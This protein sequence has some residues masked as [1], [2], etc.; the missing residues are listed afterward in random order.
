MGVDGGAVVATAVWAGMDDVEEA[1]TGGVRPTEYPV[2]YAEPKLGLGPA[3]P[4]PEPEP[5]PF[6]CRDGCD[7]GY[8]L[9]F[10]CSEISNARCRS[11]S[12]RR[13]TSSSTVGG[14]GW[15]GVSYW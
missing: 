12:S 15:A 8:P 7:V 5:P 9:R 4:E 14:G 13:R 2:E 3:A 10:S 11:A 1:A 6:W